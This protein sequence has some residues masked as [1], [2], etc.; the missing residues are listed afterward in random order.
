M[1]KKRRRS[2]PNPDRVIDP[3][4]MRFRRHRLIRRTIVTV[5]PLDAYRHAGF[6]TRRQYDAGDR[7]RDI[8]HRA[9][10][11]PKMTGDLE[12]VGHGR[13][14][15][16]QPGSSLGQAGKDA[17]AVDPASPRPRSRCLLLRAWRR[18][19]RRQSRPAGACRAHD[20]QRG[21]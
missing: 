8:W 15:D 18:V 3:N 9:G 13:R 19:V 11:A 10:R 14:D 4:E 1:A 5:T 6:L 17:Q 2:T 20:A 12:L 16:G 21:A 7:L